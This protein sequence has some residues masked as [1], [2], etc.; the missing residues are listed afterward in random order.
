MYLTGHEIQNEQAGALM[1]L[2]VVIPFCRRDPAG[3]RG[4]DNLRMVCGGQSDTILRQSIVPGPIVLSSN[5]ISKAGF[6][7]SKVGSLGALS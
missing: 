1:D 3:I 4:H 7:G 5:I 2:F 6:D